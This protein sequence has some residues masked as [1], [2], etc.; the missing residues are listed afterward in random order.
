[1]RTISDIQLPSLPQAAM[2]VVELCSRT[3]SDLSELINAVKIDGPLSS[4]LIR[5]AN[6][7]Y[8][9]QQYTVETLRKAAFILGLSYTKVVALGFHLAEA[10]ESWGTCPID[11]RP[12]WQGN[13]L[14]A[15]LGRQICD[16]AELLSLERR[17]QA[18]LV[19]LLQDLAVPLMAREAGSVYAEQMAGGACTTASLAAWERD[20]LGADHAGMVGRLTT[21]WRF[22]PQLSFSLRNHHLVPPEGLDTG[23]MAILWR[24]AWWV[25]MIPFTAETTSV[26]V[27]PRLCDRARQDF[28]LDADTLREAFTAAIEQFESLRPVFDPVLP[29]G[30]DAASLM[31]QARH[32]ILVLTGEEPGPGST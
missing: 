17:D 10:S 18:F 12:L 14:R 3:D 25:G 5:V 7:A 30:N 2:R 31:R 1:M 19:G 4:R 8:Y 13:L 26:K 27:D 22:P 32:L 11:L 24:V 15:C 23:E 21:E 16:R 20:T 6:S 28:G 29:S 9:G